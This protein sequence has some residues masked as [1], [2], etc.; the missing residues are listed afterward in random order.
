MI[1]VLEDRKSVP[2]KEICTDVSVFE[3]E[4]DRSIAKIIVVQVF[5]YLQLK[6][7]LTNAEAQ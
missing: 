7:F 4:G 3:R 5:C 2:R 1:Y 6:S